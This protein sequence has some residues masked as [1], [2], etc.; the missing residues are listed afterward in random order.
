MKGLDV[1]DVVTVQLGGSSAVVRATVAKSWKH[2]FIAKVN[3]QKALDVY[4]FSYER[5]DEGFR[6]VRGWDDE[7]ALAFRAEKALA[8]CR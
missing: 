1:G 8:S 2:R 3:P 6:W 4:S 5:R 7:T